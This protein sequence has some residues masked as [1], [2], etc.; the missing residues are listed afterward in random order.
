MATNPT[1]NGANPPADVW[2]TPEVIELQAKIAKD[3]KRLAEIHEEA[4][5][6]MEQSN[7]EINDAI[8]Q[9][10]KLT[11]ED[12]AIREKKLRKLFWVVMAGLLVV[13]VLVLVNRRIHV[14]K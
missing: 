8:R 2:P 7:L 9:I 11:K 1:N 12:T 6:Q 13:G 14:L 5:Q 10:E 3:R 4:V